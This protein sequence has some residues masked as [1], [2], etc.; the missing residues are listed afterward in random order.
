MILIAVDRRKI[1]HVRYAGDTTL[2]EESIIEMKK[3]LYESKEEC[4]TAG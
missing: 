2:L 3:F 1:Y 4:E